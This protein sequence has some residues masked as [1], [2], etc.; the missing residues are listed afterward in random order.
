MGLTVNNIINNDDFNNLVSAVKTECNRRHHVD[1]LIAPN[2]PTKNDE[3]L[4]TYS[5]VNALL[6]S[7]CGLDAF[8]DYL[9]TEVYIATNNSE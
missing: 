7:I 2:I 1:A 4:I 5:E 9:D 6:S 3:D 8:P